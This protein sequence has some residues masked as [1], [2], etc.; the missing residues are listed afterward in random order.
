VTGTTGVVVTGAKGVCNSDGFT[1]QVQVQLSAPIQTAGTFKIQLKTGS[2]GNTIINE[3]GVQTVAGSFKNFVTADT[4]SALF[5]STVHFG[6]IADSIDY[7][8]DGRN[9]VKQLEMEF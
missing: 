8:H 4:V 1:K 5:K 3:C 6:C 2:D 7:S 9:G